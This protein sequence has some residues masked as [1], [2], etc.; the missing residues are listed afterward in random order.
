MRIIVVDD[1]Q[2]IHDAI[3]QL[4]KSASDIQLVGQAY[5]GEDAMRLCRMS[6]PD[7]V[8]MD[9]VMPGMSGVE[10]TRALLKQQPGLKILVLSSFREYEYIKAML[11]SGAIGYLVK[12]AIAQD[13][14]NTIRNTIHG[15]TVFSPDIARM[16]LDP[17]SDALTQDFGLTDRERQVLEH[18]A[19]GLTNGQI[20]VAL[21]ISQ[22]TVRFHANNILLKLN[23]ETRS[24]ALVLAAKNGLV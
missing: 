11:D 14:I 8:L 7:L 19:N 16:V 20:A 1:H 18:M 22:P 13:L 10:T 5:R 3:T 4:L 23:V 21:G 6:R 12:D 9:V 24:E 15:N 17:P 2:N